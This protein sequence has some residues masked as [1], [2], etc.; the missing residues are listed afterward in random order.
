MATVA[1]ILTAVGCFSVSF[2]LFYCARALER[3]IAAESAATRNVLAT[4]SEPAPELESELAALDRK[5]R[6]LRSLV[7]DVDE[8]GERRFKT[9]TARQMRAQREQAAQEEEEAAAEMDPHQMG[10]PFPTPT[11]GN[12]PAGRM[13]PASALFRRR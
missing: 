3:I 13:L 4:S 7:E 10:F 9:L 11:N 8:R 2:V 6:E 5:V 1:Q 12:P